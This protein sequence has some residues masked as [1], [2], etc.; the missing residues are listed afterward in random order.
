MNIDIN[1]SVELEFNKYERV[2]NAKALNEDGTKI[3]N[4]TGKIKNYKVEDAAK[5][6]VETCANDNYIKD[7]VDNSIMFTLY[8]P[9]Q[10][11]I[12]GIKSKVNANVENLLKIKNKKAELINEIATKEDIDRAS[13]QNISVGKLKLYEKI[14]AVKPETTIEDVKNQPVRDLVKY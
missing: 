11:K 7:N 5:L 10:N 9:N 8:S 3:I 14:K 2:L 4:H 13:L 12:D 1:P 6:L